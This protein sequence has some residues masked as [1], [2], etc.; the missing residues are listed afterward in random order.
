MIEDRTSRFFIVIDKTIIKKQKE[1]SMILSYQTSL[2][3]M[4]VAVFN[5]HL[6]STNNEASNKI[7]K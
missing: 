3:V 4:H 5:L 6:T 1:K 2:V 7:I